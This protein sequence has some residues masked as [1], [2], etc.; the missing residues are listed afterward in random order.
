MD[1]YQGSNQHATTYKNVE[2][3]STNRLKLV[4]MV[5]DA[6]IASLKQALEYHEQGDIVRRNQFLSRSQFIVHE[7]NNALDLKRGQEI[8][9]T[10]RKLYHFLVRQLGEAIADNTVSKVHQSLGMLS[11]LREAWH[12]ISLQTMQDDT[13][14]HSSAVYH[15]GSNR[16]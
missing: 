8:A 4:V 11:D 9:S 1:T 15:G 13:S 10:L 14:Q 16:L 2:V 5:Y 12:V 3:T 7:L 6:A